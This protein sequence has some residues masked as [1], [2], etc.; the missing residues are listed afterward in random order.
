MGAV[1]LRLEV[2]GYHHEDII[3]F[4]ADDTIIIKAT[5]DVPIVLFGDFN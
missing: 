4:L 1:Y 3:E 5:H 2:C